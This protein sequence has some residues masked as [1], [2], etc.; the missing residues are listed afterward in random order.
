MIRLN[1][2]HHHS[3]L[4]IF[5]YFLNKILPSFFSSIVE[6]F[7]QLFSINVLI[8]HIFTATLL[9]SKLSISSTE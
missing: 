8:F 4:N 1:D 2:F 3:C 5:K 7:E 6:K 9:I